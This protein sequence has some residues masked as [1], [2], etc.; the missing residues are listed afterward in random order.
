MSGKRYKRLIADA[1]NRNLEQVARQLYDYWFVQFDFPSHEG[2]PYKSS[3]GEMIWNEKLKREIPLDWKAS[4][5][6]A[7][8]DIL[9]GGT[10]SK[11]VDEYWN[12]NIPFFGPTD[13]NN[14]VF[15]IETK[16]HITQSGLEHCASSL[17]DE[18][19]IIITA[20]GSI[21]KLVIVGKR[22]AM[23]QSCYALRPKNGDTEYLYFLTIE[24]IEQL[25]QKGSG[26]VFKSIIAIDIET[27]WLSIAPESIIKDFCRVCS[28]FFAKIKQN[29]IEIDRLQRLRDELLPMLLNGQVNCDLSQ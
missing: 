1:I 5:I 24:L 16:E 22:M 15:Q 7:I 17:F 25:K 2:K 4:A 29:T 11:S 21:G 9:S 12:G 20:R 27:S 18:G 6:T 28:P 10:P 19:T 3:G 13:V 8:A 14:S 23:N 26:S